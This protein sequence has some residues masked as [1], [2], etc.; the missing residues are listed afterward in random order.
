MMR[1]FVLLLCASAWVCQGKE[2]QDKTDRYVIACHTT[3][4]EC[5][6]RQYSALRDHVLLGNSQLAIEEFRPF[7][8]QYGSSCVR[9]S[10]WEE[11]EL[12]AIGMDSAN[13]ELT[14]ALELPVYIQQVKN[15]TNCAK[16]ER[17]FTGI[18]KYNAENATLM[19]FTAN[20][21]VTLVF[22]YTLLK[23]KGDVFLILDEEEVDALLDIP[24]FLMEETELEA[25][26]NKASEWAYD[27]TQHIEAAQDFAVP[28]TS[29][30]RVAMERIPFR[31]LMLLY[32]E[33]EYSNLQFAFIDF[34][35]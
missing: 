20:A 1:V 17:E 12:V 21:T 28:F 25:E 9:L 24:V 11:S 23:R 30:L 27:I 7:A 32:P 22:P 5:F 2:F 14:M 3:D 35:L 13:K 16:P 6:M 33:E 15:E 8:V 10:G 26:L 31:R 19:E 4:F 18:A 29:R 34:L